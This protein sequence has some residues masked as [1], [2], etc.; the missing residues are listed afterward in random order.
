MKEKI[1][2]VLKGERLTVENIAHKINKKYNL[3]IEDK[4]LINR[5][6]VYINRLKKDNVIEKCGIDNRYKVYKLKNDVSNEKTELIDKLILLMV[7]AGINSEEHGIDI[8]ES[9]IESNIKR[10]MECGKIG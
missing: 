9:E 3:N 2:E 4:I 7:K 10:L 5:I 1:I 8:K 6:R